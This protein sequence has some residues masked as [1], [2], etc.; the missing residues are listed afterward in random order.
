MESNLNISN[1]TSLPFADYVVGSYSTMGAVIEDGTPLID[2]NKAKKLREA[3]A[4][5]AATNGGTLLL[6]E[7]NKQKGKKR[8]KQPKPVPDFE[9]PEYTYKVP[10]PTIIDEAPVINLNIVDNK[11]KVNK[12]KI[13]FSNDFG[14]IKSYVEDVLDSDVAIALVYKDE[15]AVNFIP[16]ITETLSLQIENN[17]PINVYYPGALFTWTDQIKNIIILFKKDHE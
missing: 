4:R 6:P 15:E 14:Q 13:T 5:S 7:I 17:D 11:P 8:T 9:L 2:A 3:T 1:L 12:K 16:K 10:K